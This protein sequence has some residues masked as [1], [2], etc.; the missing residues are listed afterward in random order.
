MLKMA[1][2]GLWVGGVNNVFIPVIFE[3]IAIKCPRSSF[4]NE[5]YLDPVLAKHNKYNKTSNRELKIN[6]MLLIWSK[7]RLVQIPRYLVTHLFLAAAIRC[8]KN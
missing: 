7:G 8:W 4:V 1:F 2:F 6:S 5:T 3:I